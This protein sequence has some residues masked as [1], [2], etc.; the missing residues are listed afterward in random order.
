MRIAIVNDLLIATV[1]LRRAITQAGHD[2]AWTAGDGAVAIEACRR[3]TPD[4]ILM[5]LVMP[6][7]G[8][9]EA[10]RRIMAETPCRILLVTASVTENVA[11]VFEAMGYGALDA[12]NTP[13]LMGDGASGVKPLLDKI[14]IIGKL[15]ANFEPRRAPHALVAMGASA[16]GPAALAT[17]LR[18]LPADFPAGIA[19]VQHVD[20]QFVPGMAQWLSGQTK[21][22]V[23]I[24]RENDAP[25]GGV[26][27]LAASEEHLQLR[28]D[29]R[30][31]YTALPAD[32]PYRPSV[33][34]FFKSVAEN[35][36]G[37]TAGV[38]LTG[39]GRDGAVG[40]KLLR[41]HGATTIAQDRASS[42]VYGM[43]R[44][45]ALMDAATDILPLDRIAPRLIE[46]FGT[47][48]E[49]TAHDDR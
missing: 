18:A 45:A 39:M 15:A 10:T 26:V 43:P 28:P 24:A 46:I 29:G 3:D 37:R 22:R 23:V 2:V 38:L 19:L 47:K 41:A 32:Y 4:L 34:V 40:L 14:A 16:G 8:G 13:A 25:S 11:Q 5:D 30:L 36:G 44:A 31:G 9:V 7:I 35:F 12:V 20:P 17:V 21:L 27:H 6:G 48:A 42:A 49:K 1:A 33:D